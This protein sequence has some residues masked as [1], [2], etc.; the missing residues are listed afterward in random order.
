MPRR[1]LRGARIL[2]TGASSGIGAAT[3]RLLARR[4]AR[5]ILT[6]RRRERLESLAATI[7]SECQADDI[8]RTRQTEFSTA[9]DSRAADAL[10]QVVCCPGDITDPV[11][12]CRLAEQV[13][14]TFEHLD[15]LINNAGV[16]AVGPF[17]D[18]SPQR[19]RQV[20]E[21]NFFAPAELTRRMLPLFEAPFQTPSNA[22]R[23]PLLVVVGSVL[24]HCAMP[25]KSEYCASKFALR[26]LS[27]AL[28]CEL[29]R[30]GIGV[31]T[32][33]PN[34]TR[35]EFFDA[36][37]ERKGEVAHNRWQQSTDQVA[38]RL[39]R[40]IERGRSRQILTLSGKTLVW[41]NRWVPALVTRLLAR[42]G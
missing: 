20:M 30:E 31:L 18:A 15:I 41:T 7:R 11:H 23:S 40:A 42:F 38:A 9:A 27:D 32:V 17:R 33:D 1:S 25:N 28:R 34:T 12:R 8:R 13:E 21:T 24:A 39:V 35:S 10:E 14:Q 29:R 6:A 4:G 2:L 19:L 22:K 37:V 16:G 5:L 36:L 26:G 3:A